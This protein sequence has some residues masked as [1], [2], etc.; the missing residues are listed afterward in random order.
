M[1]TWLRRLLYLLIVVVWLLVM[2]FPF[3][4]FKLATDG[5]LLIGN[6]GRHVRLFL[7]QERTANGVGVEWTRPFSR[8]RSC[9]RTSITYL[10]WEGEGEN[11]TYCQCFDTQ[12]NSLLTSGTCPGE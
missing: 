12:S 4:A 11:V 5:Q 6:N 9:T 7:I 2:S 1:R 3:V 8:D 10:L